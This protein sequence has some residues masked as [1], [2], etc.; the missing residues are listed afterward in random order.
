MFTN[1]IRAVSYHAGKS[2]AEDKGYVAGLLW[3][4]DAGKSW[5]NKVVRQMEAADNRGK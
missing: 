2:P 1:N 3:G 4:G 5:A